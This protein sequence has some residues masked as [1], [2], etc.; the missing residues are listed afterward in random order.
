MKDSKTN[1]S[2][3][4]RSPGTDANSIPEIYDRTMQAVDYIENLSDHD[5]EVSKVIT[6]CSTLVIYAKGAQTSDPYLMIDEITI[7]HVNHLYELDEMLDNGSETHTGIRC[8][9]ESEC[10]NSDCGTCIFAQLKHIDISRLSNAIQSTVTSGGV[11]RNR[12]I[13]H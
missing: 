3:K 10:G 11:T 1:T 2:A 9:H 5:P 4:A 13:M 7:D 6:T 8:P 12:F